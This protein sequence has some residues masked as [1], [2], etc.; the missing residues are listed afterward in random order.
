MRFDPI[1]LTEQLDQLTVSGLLTPAN[2]LR[3]LQE[4]LRSL[5]ITGIDGARQFEDSLN[6]LL[7]DSVRRGQRL[8]LFSQRFRAH[9]EPPYHAQCSTR[10]LQ[11][12]R[13]H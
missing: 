1:C 9:P 3:G 6:P 11:F 12:N 13:V 7:D 5:P 4:R 10:Y 8:Q 2:E